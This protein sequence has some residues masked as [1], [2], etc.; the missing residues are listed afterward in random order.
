MSITK[1]KIHKN[2]VIKLCKMCTLKA[3]KQNWKKFFKNLN[4][5]ISTVCVQLMGEKITV[6]MK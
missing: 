1:N 3:I 5:T 4:G 2:K 6:M